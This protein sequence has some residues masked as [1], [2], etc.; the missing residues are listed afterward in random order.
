MKEGWYKYSA[1][2]DRFPG[3]IFCGDTREDCLLRL[4][5]ESFSG[6]WIR[7]IVS[8]G[9]NEIIA[10]TDT[11]KIVFRWLPEDHPDAKGLSF[12][13]MRRE[14]ASNLMNDVYGK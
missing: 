3:A 4:Q 2:A 8:I 14:F 6:T 5:E 11:G 12:G 7:E 9:D 13:E 1:N 10:T